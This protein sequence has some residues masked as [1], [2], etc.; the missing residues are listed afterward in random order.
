[1]PGLNDWVNKAFGDLVASIKLSDDRRVFDC[2]VFHTHQSAEKALKAYLIF[3]RKPIPKTHDLGMLLDSC[4]ECD[5]A[6]LLLQYESK[7]LN[8]YA[9]ESR[10]PNDFFHIDQPKVEEAIRLSQK[11][12]SFVQI[13]LG[14]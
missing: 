14:L 4:A 11:I 8:P 2:S 10:Y 12:L 1:M 3:A 13:K 5:P 7:V 9:S 6:F